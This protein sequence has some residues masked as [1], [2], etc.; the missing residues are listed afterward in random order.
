[1]MIKPGITE[2]SKCVDSRYTLVSMAAKRA[3]MIGNER[4][5]DSEAYGN[6][7]SVT[8][9]ADEIASGK[10]GYIRSE[11]VEKARAWESE[12]AAAILSLNNSE[13]YETEEEEIAQDTA[14]DI[15]EDDAE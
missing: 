9:A 5:E 14:E 1:M 7:K 15:A 2:L 10:V 6:E 4:M 8:V 3:R 13:D 12:K 11:A